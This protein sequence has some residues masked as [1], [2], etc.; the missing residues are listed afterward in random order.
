MTGFTYDTGALIAAEV[1]DRA[2]W[3]LHIEL[4]QRKISPTIPAGVLGEAWRGGPQALLSRL[5][6][7]CRIEP[8]AEDQARAVVVLAAHCGLDDTVD[9]A[10]GALR[11]RDVVSPPTASTSNRSPTVS[12]AS[13]PLW[14]LTLTW[15]LA[16][17]SISPILGP[18]QSPKE[19]NGQLIALAGCSGQ[20]L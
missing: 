5:I 10:G 12:D 16:M 8:L 7:G 6:K 14:T 4:L 18:T 20:A 19:E 9:L 17:V 15:V 1:N 11:R 13:S 2:V 3:A